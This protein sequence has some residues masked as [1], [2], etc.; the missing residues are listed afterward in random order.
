MVKNINL[1]VQLLW[2]RLSAAYHVRAIGAQKRGDMLHVY[3]FGTLS[4]LSSLIYGFH[5]MHHAPSL[6]RK[7]RKRWPAIVLWAL[8]WGGQSLIILGILFG[9]AQA[10]GV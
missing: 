1:I 6:R 10:G 7:L 9:G 2:V 4:L 5:F 3:V 8:Y